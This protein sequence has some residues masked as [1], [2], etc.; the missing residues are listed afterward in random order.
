MQLD[1]GGKTCSMTVNS[2]GVC[3]CS[4]SDVF[5]RS[6][7]IVQTPNPSFAPAV[8][9]IEPMPQRRS[10]KHDDDFGGG[11]EPIP[12]M[13]WIPFVPITVPENSIPCKKHCVDPC[14]QSQSNGESFCCDSIDGKCSVTQ[15]D[16]K[17]YCS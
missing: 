12:W 1:H 2:I 17:C 4:N 3:M 5:S 11:F 7:P 6:T 14:S 8:A 9:N 13:P 16:G 15:I 10:K